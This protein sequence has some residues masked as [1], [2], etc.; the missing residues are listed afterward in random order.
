LVQVDFN[1]DQFRD[2]SGVP[3]FAGPGRDKVLNARAGG[4]GKRLLE[5]VADLVNVTGLFFWALHECRI[6]VGWGRGIV[7]THLR[8]GTSHDVVAMGEGAQG[9]SA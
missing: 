6:P 4:F 7:K 9:G 1:L 8:A 3:G 2:Q 5:G